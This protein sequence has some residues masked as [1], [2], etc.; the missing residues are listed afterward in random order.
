MIERELGIREFLSDSKYTL[1]PGVLFVSGASR[2][3]IYDINTER[4]FSLNPGACKILSGEVGNP[5]FWVELE[6]LSLATKG[7]KEKRSVLPELLQKPELQFVWFEIISD[8]CN[9][10]CIH[11]YA[12]SMPLSYRKALGLPTDGHLPLEDVTANSFGQKEKLNFTQ[13]KNLITEAYSLGCRRCQFIGG[14]PFL[15]KGEDGETVLDLAEHAKKTGYEFIEIFTNATLLTQKKIEKIKEFGLSIA[16]SLYS[17]DPAVH[18]KITRTPGSHRKTMN[19]LRLLKEAG[20][21][22]RVETVLMRDNEHTVQQTQDI[23][24]EIG[25]N[26]KNPDVLRPRGRGNNPSIT[27]SKETVVKYGL[28]ISPNFRADRETLSRYISG[29]SCLSGKTTITDDGDVLPCI[30]SRNLAVGNVIKNSL[31]EIISGKELETIWRSTKDDV[32][33][34]QDCEYRYACFDCRPLSEGINQGR[35]EYLSAPYP[36]C[37]YNPYAGEWAK[38]VWRVDEGGKPYYDKA[39]RPIIEEIM[40][41]SNDEYHV[42]R[43]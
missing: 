1:A 39:L 26:H 6:K 9:E 7:E 8:D 17:N 31:S 20:I 5:K 28:M 33:V 23:I 41:L 37:T 13:W 30:F 27:P 34:C 42:E 10:S 19:A 4:V 18:D 35:G 14:E 36:R 11:C 40:T 12:D 25:F 15:Y 24:N 21:P 3:A 32:L 43:G 29:H 38:G 22:T 16:V 2:G